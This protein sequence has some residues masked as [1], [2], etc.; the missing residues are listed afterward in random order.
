MLITLEMGQVRFFIL[1]SS[2]VVIIIV[3]FCYYYYCYCCSHI[4][5]KVQGNK[6]SNP[7]NRR[8]ACNF[9]ICCLNAT[10]SS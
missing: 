3:L 5:V 7:L 1:T 10:F 4:L 6:I 9:S 8:I 2:F